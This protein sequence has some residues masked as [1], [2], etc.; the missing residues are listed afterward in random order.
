MVELRPARFDQFIKEV[1]LH[2]SL[3][4]GYPL[5]NG[6][7]AGGTLGVSPTRIPSAHLIHKTTQIGVYSLGYRQLDDLKTREDS[8]HS[9]TASWKYIGFA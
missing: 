7:P 6:D 2:L 5:A 9:W 1:L 4:C 3:L 8:S